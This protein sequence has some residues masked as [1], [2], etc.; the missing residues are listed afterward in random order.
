LSEIGCPRVSPADNPKWTWLQ[1]RSKR[2]GHSEGAKAHA[3][4][5]SDVKTRNLTT[6]CWIDLATAQLLPSSMGPLNP[7]ALSSS[8][9][10]YTL[11]ETVKIWLLIS[12]SVLD[13]ILV[14][15]F[16]YY[17]YIHIYIA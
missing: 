4:E 13:I 9:P 17:I 11:S 10:G 1:N 8:Q 14:I 5:M 16:L 2:A 6:N 15:N 7:E 12:D 3:L